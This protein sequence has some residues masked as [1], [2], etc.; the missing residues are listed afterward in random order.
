MKHQ[1][2]FFFR[3]TRW[4]DMHKKTTSV[5]STKLHDKVEKKV[6]KNAMPSFDNEPLKDTEIYLNYLWKQF[7]M[8]IWMWW[9]K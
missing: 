3:T 5:S 1:L 2:K 9:N 7:Q 6:M 4:T 8:R